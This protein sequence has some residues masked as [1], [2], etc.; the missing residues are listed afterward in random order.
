MIVHLYDAHEHIKC[1]ELF[2]TKHIHALL[3]VTYLVPYN[4]MKN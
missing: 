2:G 3:L 1:T 4:R